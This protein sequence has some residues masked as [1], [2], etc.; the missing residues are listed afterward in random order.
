MSSV[1]LVVITGASSGIG[2]ALAKELHVQGYSLIVVARR[3]QALQ[4]LKNDLEKLRANSVQIR[5]CDLSKR[6][7]VEGLA[8]ELESQEVAGLV[9]NAGVGSLG[10]FHSLDL[11]SELNQIELN[12]VTPLVLTH[13]IVKGM[14][15]RKSGFIINVSSIMAYQAVPYVATYAATKAF[16]WRHSIALQRELSD[17]GIRVLTLCPG[18]TETEFFGVAKVPGGIKKFKRA[19]ASLVA[20]VCLEDLKAGR[21]I[22]IPTF[23]AKSLVLLGMLAPTSIY[24]W[25]VKR[26]LSPVLNK[27]SHVNS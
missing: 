27:K 12:V 10:A 14:C 2:Q 7:E 3:E 9:N 11:A 25:Y 20:K 16:E 24:T 18:P 19:P 15:A 1:P 23:L 26:V 6:I 4:V 13:S 21:K 22:S 17:Y 5:V 8:K